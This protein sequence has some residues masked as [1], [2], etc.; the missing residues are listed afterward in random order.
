MTMTSSLPR[1]QRQR[2]RKVHQE[3]QQE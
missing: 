2:W 1:R 3:P